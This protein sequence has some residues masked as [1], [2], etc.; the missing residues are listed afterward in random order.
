M[1]SP[2]RRWG[3]T[4]ASCD[5]GVAPGPSL[6]DEKMMGVIPRAIHNIF[7]RIYDADESFEFTVK[8]S[9]VEIYMERLRDLLNPEA[10]V[11]Q[12]IAATPGLA[13]V[14]G[15]CVRSWERFV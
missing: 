10:T 15:T 9:Y 11:R 1:A 6:D 5:A 7:D 14:R 12:R 13:A 4:C 3:L 2:S 8:I